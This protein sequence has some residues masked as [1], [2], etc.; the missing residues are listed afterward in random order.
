[1]KA[2]ICTGILLV[3]ANAL[4]FVACG[5]MSPSLS[6]Q[7]GSSAATIAVGTTTTLPPGSKATVSDSGSTSAAILN[8]GIPA[9]LPGAKALVLPSKLVA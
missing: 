2:I 5:G 3:L 7:Q 6:A 1:M 9:G 8:F 4:W